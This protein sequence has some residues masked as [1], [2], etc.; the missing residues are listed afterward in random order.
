MLLSRLF[1][2]WFWNFVQYT[3]KVKKMHYKLKLQNIFLTK[4]ERETQ[5]R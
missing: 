2:P 5:G 3:I 4:E 1:A